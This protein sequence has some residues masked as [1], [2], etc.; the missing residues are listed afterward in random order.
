MRDI[1]RRRFLQTTGA[2]GIGAMLSFSGV[3]SADTPSTLVDDAFEE[4]NDSPQEALIVFD[5]NDAVDQLSTLSLSNDF[6]KFEVLPIGYTELSG[7]RLTD[8]A[9]L[10]SVQ[11]VERNTK[12][13]YYNDDTRGLLRTDEAQSGAGSSLDAAYSGESAHTAVID[14]GVDGDHPDLENSIEN[15]YEWAGNPV[16]SSPLWVDVG[17]VDTDN[18]GHGTHTSGTIVGDGTESDGRFKGHAP[19][20][21]LTMYAA[22]LVLTLIKP[23]A[24]YDHLLANH[25]DEVQVVSNSYGLSSEDDFDPMLALN[26]ATWEAYN[27]GLLSVFSAGNSGSSTNTLNDYAKAP[28]VLGV[29]ATNDS[30]SVT[31]FSSRGRAPDYSGNGEGANYDRQAALNNLRKY[32]GGRLPS[33]PLGL[34]RIGVGAPGNEIVSTMTPNDPLQEGSTDDGRPYYATL[35]GTSMSCPAT[36]GIATLVVDAYQQNS[37]SE[38]APIDVLNTIE[39]TSEKPKNSYTLANMGAGFPDGYAAVVRAEAGDLASAVEET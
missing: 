32:Y 25:G 26:V 2:A 14:T 4:S 37:G 13:E 3:A 21:S 20:A 10:D 27:S 15:H 11:R 34:Y 38:P 39:A 29:A 18:S 6:H 1:S 12:L 33:G 28:H 24:A 16:G 9:N 17:P 30:K 36:A 31:E 22:D 8:V 5:S 35:S 7:T 23:V 19:D